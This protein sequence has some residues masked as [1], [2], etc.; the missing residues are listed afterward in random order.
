M[1]LSSIHL[2]AFSELC[3]TSSFSAAAKN[4]HVTQSA[5]S[6]RIKNLEEDLKATLV[7]RDRASLK[8]TLAGERLL[9]FCTTREKLENECIE[10]IVGTTDEASGVINISAFSTI[11]RSVV[12]PSLSRLIRELPN[13]KI[14]FSSKEIRDLPS[15]LQRGEAD[16][17]FL[18]QEVVRE[19]VTSK[20]LGYEKNVLIKSSHHE[21]IPDR[22]LDH[23][24]DDT[25]TKDFFNR[26]KKKT[27][28]LKRGF[29]DEI[30]TIIDGVKEGH[31]KAI[32]PMHLAK[33]EK[34][35]KIAR[36]FLPL[37]V[38]IYLHYFE[39]G[40]LTKLEAKVLTELC[41][42]FPKYLGA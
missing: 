36:G 17:I 25:T 24:S 14:N 4:L 12:I 35:I 42:N 19:G 16:I 23:G 38:P 41:K 5:L 30:Y 18:P 34:G 39:K 11:L 26:Q 9:Q 32:V 31:G 37:K 13:C 6:Q 15:S 20:L 27:K 29:Y 3:R 28:K 22:F 21:S 7:I 40:Y 33:K 2:D 8:L 1:S 10:E